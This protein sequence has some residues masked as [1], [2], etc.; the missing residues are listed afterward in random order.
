M[1]T[2]INETED[3][4]AFGRDFMKLTEDREAQNEVLGALIRAMVLGVSDSDKK[5]A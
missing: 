1:Y 4:K 5:P 2:P 3:T